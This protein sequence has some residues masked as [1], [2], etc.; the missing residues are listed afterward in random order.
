MSVF[1]P[2]DALLFIGFLHV[3]FMFA[4]Y[5][6]RKN[7]AFSEGNMKETRRKHEEDQKETRRKPCFSPPG[8]SETNFQHQGGPGIKKPSIGR[9]FF[10]N[11][12]LLV[13]D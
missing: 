5:L 13:F 6:L 9:R 1:F 12:I 7:G 3:S 8:L 11:V 4:S 10:M 2:G